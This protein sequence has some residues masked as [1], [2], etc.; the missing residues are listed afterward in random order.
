MSAPP[1]H[2]LDR[3]TVTPA[4]DGLV[5][6]TVLL[7]PDLVRDYCHFLESLASF[8]ATADRRI[9]TAQQESGER[10]RS[11]YRTS[12]APYRF[13]KSFPALAYLQRQ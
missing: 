3:L 12:P 5:A 9:K 1:V 6:V 11:D 4:T 7:P 13:S 2:F 8:I 10:R